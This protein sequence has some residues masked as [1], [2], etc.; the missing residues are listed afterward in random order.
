MDIKKHLTNAMYNLL[1][2]NRIENITVSMVLK[3]SNISRGTFYRYF[4]DKYDLM[5]SYYE[6]NYDVFFKN[7]DDTWEN[8]VSGIVFFIYQNKLF[9][10]NA[11]KAEGQNSYEHF[12]HEHATAFCRTKYKKSKNIL[13]L[14]AEEEA[15]IQYFC[16][17]SI[18]IVK[19]WIEG[20]MDFEPQIVSNIICKN[21][22]DL[23][24]NI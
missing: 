16:A 22:P 9:F 7:Y 19:L 8:I 4:R 24:R 23:I 13:K 21:M 12:L 1:K 6:T 10:Q 17:G 14:S 18:L 15:T 3:E 20:K 5:N 2:Q 11:F